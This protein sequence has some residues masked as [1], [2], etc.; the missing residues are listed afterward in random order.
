MTGSLQEKD[1][2]FYIV[3]NY[4]DNRGKRK[5]KWFKTGLHTKGNR[6]KAEQMMAEYITK[7]QHLDLSDTSELLFTTAVKQWIVNKKH[8]IELSTW[9]AYEIFANKHIIPY[10]E[11][12]KLTIQDVTAKHIKNYYDYKTSDGRADGKPGG[13][14]VQSIRKHAIVI[15]QVFDD[16]VMSEHITRNPAR[17]V[18]LPKQEKT[19]L[20]GIFLTQAEANT[21]LDAFKGED[22]QPLVYVTLYYGLR[23]GEVLGLKWSA[24]DFE[25]NVIRIR[26]TVVATNTIVAKDKTKSVTSNRSFTLLPEIKELLLKL[27]IAQEKSKQLFGNCYKENDY[28]FKWSDGKTYR[29]DYITKKFH[30]IMNAHAL[31]AMRFHDLRHS[32]ASIL[33]DKGWSL[34]DIQEWLGH[35]DISVTSNIYTTSAI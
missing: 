9:E 16:A 4:K 26:H 25:N 7:Y 21:L 5:Q 35:A 12:M 14:N 24:V 17:M 23:R 33:Y 31:K 34:K 2:K 19:G 30:K 11:P 18:P 27:K 32:T 29:P 13:L 15:N 3:L 1:N 6:R 8:S 20:K 28:I 22:L 10:F